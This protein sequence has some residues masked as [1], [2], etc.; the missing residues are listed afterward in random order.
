MRHLP[1]SSN[2]CDYMSR[3]PRALDDYGASE[4]QDMDLEADDDFCISTIITNDLPDAVELKT[5]QR[6]TQ[7]DAVVTLGT[8]YVSGAELGLESSGSADRQGH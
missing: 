5:V 8:Q 1:G 6:A 2:T 3:H 4:W 7:E